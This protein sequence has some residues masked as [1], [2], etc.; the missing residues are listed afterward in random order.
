MSSVTRNRADS[1][2][3]TVA[4]LLAV[5]MHA[6][7]AWLPVSWRPVLPQPMVLRV[8]LATPPPVIVTQSSESDTTSAPVT[9]P[10]SE[11][12]TPTNPAPPAASIAPVAP[13]ALAKPATPPPKTKPKNPLKPP[14]PKPIKPVTPPPIAVKTTKP[15]P[16]PL[17]KSKPLKPIERPPVTTK[18]VEN[19]QPTGRSFEHTLTPRAEQTASTASV[20]SK[21][22]GDDKPAEGW[23]NM[24]DG[25]SSST[26]TEA[27]SASP[28]KSAR[29]AAPPVTGI[30]PLPGNPAPRYPPQAR[31]RGI[32]GRVLLRLTINAAGSVEAVS[33]AQGSGNDLLDQEAR[34]TVARWRFQPPGR[35]QVVIQRISFGLQD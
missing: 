18:T 24:A 28:A 5:A 19:T 31:Q 20:S 27:A 3:L 17:L 26:G 15:A 8:T 33:I 6:G 22:G 16:I 34:S 30:R 32:E 7:L 14:K 10:I 1:S 12:V 2:R 29:S 11:P 23:S 4:V 35:S 9:A 21:F 25:H 13:I